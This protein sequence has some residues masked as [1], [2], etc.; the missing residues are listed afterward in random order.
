VPADW[1]S[2]LRYT[3]VGQWLAV[4]GEPWVNS[5][6]DL[7]R[8][9]G[10]AFVSASLMEQPRMLSR[11]IGD[12]F[13]LNML[14]RTGW[15]QLHA[16]CLYRDGRALLLHG[17][18]NAGKSTTAFRLAMNGYRLVSD[19]MTYVRR[20]EQGV[21][22]L[23]YPVGEVKLRLDMLEEFRQVKVREA[24][25]V[26][27]DTKMVYDLRQEM[28]ERVVEE[29]IR[30]QRI[31]LCLLERTGRRETTAERIASSVA[32]DA[33]LSESTFRDDMEVL[34]SNLESIQALLAMTDC[35]HLRV[36]TDVKGI[37]DTVD[38]LQ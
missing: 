12:C 9:I 15:G 16:S 33:L 10:V 31:V 1:P 24:A 13:V 3:G 8:W 28:P 32:L 29:A 18:H 2:R 6:A 38:S 30:P 7:Q 21:E 4:N 11:F 36:G 14:M 35:Y 27:E 23:G 25:L 22:L 5:F 17:R 19:G 20:L 37:V 34:V 26:R